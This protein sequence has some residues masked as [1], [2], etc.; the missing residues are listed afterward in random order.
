M[1]F[2]NSLSIILVILT[3][4]IS[5]KQKVT[6]EPC[7]RVKTTTPN[8]PS[9]TEGDRN[10]TVEVINEKCD[11]TQPSSEGPFFLPNQPIRQ[12]IR[13]GRPGVPLKVEFTVKNTTCHPVQDAQVHVWHADALG[14]YSAY[15]DYYPLGDPSAK[16]QITGPHAEPSEEAT[17]LRGIQLT[18]SNGRAK[19]ETIYPGWYHVRTLHLHLKVTL[20]GKDKYTGE[21]YFPDWLTD[22]IAKVEPYKSHDE[23]RL[24]NDDDSQFVRENGEDLLMTPKG[25][26]DDG[27]EGQIEIII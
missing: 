22:K 10:C 26:L 27:F 6:A 12:D 4:N 16:L 15:S 20:A 18:D 11:L 23:K 21:I 13:E 8:Q 1:V 24:K 5:H 19:F 2:I 25:N 9:C 3:S 14:V 17:F 7:F